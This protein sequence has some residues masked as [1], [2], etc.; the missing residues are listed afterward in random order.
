MLKIILKAL[1]GTAVVLITIVGFVAVI[2]VGLE[3]AEEAFGR[4]SPIVVMAVACA[5]IIFSLFVSFFRFDEKQKT[6]L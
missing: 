3:Y 1:L 6:E 4:W 5:I 2:A